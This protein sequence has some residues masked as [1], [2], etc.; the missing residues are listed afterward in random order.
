MNYIKL[1][2]ENNE[3]QEEF[4]AGLFAYQFEDEVANLKIGDKLILKREPKNKHDKNAI[5]VCIRKRV[6]FFGRE[7]IKLGHICADTAYKLAPIMDQGTKL[8]GVIGYIDSHPNCH[9]LAISIQKGGL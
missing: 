4:I 5:E 3:N 7:D 9:R 8:H 2:S 1:S 6:S